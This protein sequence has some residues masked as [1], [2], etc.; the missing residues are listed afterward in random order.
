MYFQNPKRYGAEILRECSPPH[1]SHVM[2]H[3][4]H[5]ICH[6]SCVNFL[7][8]KMTELVGGGSVINEAYF[9]EIAES[10]I[11]A[12]NPVYVVFINA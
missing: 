2:R 3:V 1:A 5:V 6:V 8:D 9:E 10:F 4:S 7:C 11:T 12:L